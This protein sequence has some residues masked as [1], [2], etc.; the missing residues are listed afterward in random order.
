MSIEQAG[1]RKG[2]GTRDQ[3]A[4]L[5]WIMELAKEYQQ[6]VY[7]CFIDYSK[8]FD[9]VNYSTMWNVMR[10][11]GIPEHIVQLIENLYDKQEA[12][13]RTEHRDTETFGI[14]KGVRQG[15]ILSPFLFNLYSESIMRKANID[16]MNMGIRIGGRRINNLR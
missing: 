4:N 13:V 2:K 7:M 12:E 16:K 3:I 15:C 5:R 14:G 11:M 6:P 9:C 8:V 10:E 1:F